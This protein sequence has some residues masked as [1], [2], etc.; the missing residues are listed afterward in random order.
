MQERAGL[1][2]EG[3]RGT[4][5]RWLLL[6][7]VSLN[8][9]ALYVHRNLI[10]YFQPPLQDDLALDQFQL[11]LLRWGF[12]LPYCLAQLWVGYL[13]D[14]YRRRTVLLV[15]L[16]ASTV[17]LGLMGL[18]RSFESLLALRILLALAQS[19]SVPAIASVIADC[20][21]PRT[22]STA[23]GIYLVSYNF[24]LVV[25]GW[26]G[27]MVADKAVWNVPAFFSD[28]PDLEVAGWRMSFFLF[29]A[30][31][32]VVALVLLI[33]FREPRRTDRGDEV[34]DGKTEMGRWQAVGS[35]LRIPTYRAIAFVFVSTGVVISAV[36]YW[37]P[38]Y[39]TD[40]FGLSLA[41]AGLQAT[42][43]IQSATVLG[44][45]C[46]GKWAD[47]WAVRSQT[48]RTI[49]QL[50]GLIGCGPALIVIATTESQTVM[51]AA[52]L[53]L[54]FGVGMYQA[55]LWTCTFEIVDP[56]ARATAIGLL[57]LS[58]GVFGSWGDPIIGRVADSGVGLDQ[59]LASIGVAPILSVGVM[60]F[61][62]KYLLPHD[63]QT[64]SGQSAAR[65]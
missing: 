33:F 58:S 54:G 24:S 49:V 61:S 65:G 10:N 52:M 19:P 5:D 8:Y 34:D 56:K 4:P 43:W 62:I 26:L 42:I 13:G 2:S 16:V 31:G 18:A 48:G 6:T 63:Y 40:H 11:G 28:S 3:S 32:G 55:N 47:N 1:G 25:A 50:I 30:V 27:G 39:L 46:G 41:D 9:F 7:L 12:V 51:A 22:R 60:W 17:A 21:T 57:N 59:I 29:A 20:F 36:Q 23:V 37:L 14:R 45:F 15:S 35:V 44:L 64:P 53:V 38:R